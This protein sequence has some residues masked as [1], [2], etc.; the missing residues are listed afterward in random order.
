M[1]DLEFAVPKSQKV[2]LRYYDIN[3]KL[4]YVITQNEINGIYT[5][6]KYDS[7]GKKLVK[8]RTANSPLKFDEVY[9]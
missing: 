9:K 1:N 4:Q 7:K 3:H 2:T 5:L 6:F 8:V